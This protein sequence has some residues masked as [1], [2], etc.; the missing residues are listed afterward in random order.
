MSTEAGERLAGQVGAV[1]PDGPPE[2]AQVRFTEPVKPLVGV[3]V[4]VEVPLLPFV[5]EIVV[6][7]AARL[8]L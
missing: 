3:T 2:I 8:K 7:L 5:R 6:G 1:A 4:I